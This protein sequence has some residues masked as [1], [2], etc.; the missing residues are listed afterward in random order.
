MKKTLIQISWVMAIALIAIPSYSQSQGQK[1]KLSQ[2][3]IEK[4]ER[5]VAEKVALLGRYITN[6]AYKYKDMT[7]EEQIQK[8]EYYRKSALNLFINRG[9]EYDVI[10]T[11]KKKLDNGE[12][13]TEK[14][15]IHKKG[16]IMEVT[17][18]KDPDNPSRNTVKT[19]LK[20]LMNLKYYQVE[21]KT[22]DWWN[23]RVTKPK[24]IAN[25]LYFCTCYFKQEFHGESRE[26]W[27]Y[28]DVT[29]KRVD[30]YIYV[31]ETEEG[32]EYQIMLGDVRALETRRE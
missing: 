17:S 11:T 25:N 16:A 2:E 32:L 13:K 22:T 28:I 27:D 14:D 5:R 7:N 21:I 3:Q 20:G 8:K 10:T 19:Y 12:I 18:L 9:D 4:M 1:I 24:K 26:G 30:C 31:L 6:I 23:M 15:T 29:C